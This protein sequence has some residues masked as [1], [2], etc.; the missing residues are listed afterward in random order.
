MDGG[1]ESIFG[2]IIGVIRTSNRERQSFAFIAEIAIGK[3]PK[4]TDARN[5]NKVFV[6]TIAPCLEECAPI[7][8]G[9]M[10]LRDI[11]YV[12]IENIAIY[13]I[14]SPYQLITFK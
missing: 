5:V 6:V 14:E 1:N 2:K 13:P 11:L 12:F 10:G 9:G 4:L 8:I 7:Y 3:A